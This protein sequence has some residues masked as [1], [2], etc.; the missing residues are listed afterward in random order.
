MRL[1][2]SPWSH[3]RRGFPAARRTG[4]APVAMAGGGCAA[5]HREERQKMLAGASTVQGTRREEQQWKA[6]TEGLQSHP[7]HRD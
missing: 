7:R 3:G 5:G 2:G 1:Q 6:G 4:D